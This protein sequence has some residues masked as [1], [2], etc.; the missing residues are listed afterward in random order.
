MADFD[1]PHID[2]TP[3]VLTRP[4]QAS[5]QNIGGGAAPRVRAQ[6]GARLQAEM[7][8]AFLE[9]DAI[10]PQDDR[11]ERP[12]G[13]FLEV[14]LR[15]GTNP[16]D[17]LE[18]KR[19]K[20]RPGAVSTTEDNEVRVALFVPDDARP[21]VERI[22]AEYLNGDVNARGE[23]P[24]KNKVEPIEAIRRARLETFWTDDP[25]TL[26]LEPQD[27]IWWEV[28]CYAELANK[29]RDA[30]QNINC[31][32]AEE[33]YWLRFPESIVIPIH[34]TRVTIELLLFASAGISELRRASASP[35]FFIE[36][37]HEEQSQ[38]T[39]NLAERV[40]WPAGD[41]PAVCLLDTG[42]NR[43]HILLEPA[44]SADDLLTVKAD[45]GTA[46]DAGHGTGMAGLALLG[47]LAPRLED[48]SEI[49][50]RHRVESVKILP[51]NGF[52]PN[53]PKSFGSITQSAASLAEINKPARKRVFCLAVTNDN[54][55]GARATTWSSAIDQ[56]AVGKMA[57][58][59]EDAPSRLLVVS[60]GNAPSEI[61]VNNILPADQLPIEDPSQAW[62]ALS[63]GGY[64]NKTDISDEGYDGW[65]AMATAGDLSPFT[66]TSVTWP[67][68]RTAFKPDVVMEAGNRAISPAGAEAL[69]LDSLALLTTGENVDTQPLI[70][71][72]AT[73]AAAAQCARL[74]TQL[75]AA[76]PEMW[77]ETIRAL[78]V[79]S[80][81]WTPKML[82]ELE[83]AG[84]MTARH[85]LL[86]RFGH[87]VPDLSRA[88]ASA[89]NHLALIAQNEIT[90]FKV[91]NGQKKFSDCHF[92][93]L[94]WPKD[95][96]EDLGEQDVRLKLTLS[97]FVEPNPGRFASIDA[98]RY[99]SFGLRF[100]L[101]RRSES[102]D[103]FLK[104]TNPMERDDP[105]GP[106]P[107]GGDNSGWK[108]GPNS[109]SA[110]S[111]HSD[112][113]V[114]PAVTLAARDIVCVKPVIGWWRQSARNC[115]RSGRYALVVTL[116]APNIEVDLHTP[117]QLAVENQV[118]IEIPF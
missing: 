15:R 118:D 102:E 60:A 48:L 69:N 63:V 66:R 81:E 3:R 86:R 40:I 30:A 71:F 115:R 34:A 80:A 10:R 26:P 93:K 47:D 74:A 94:P 107:P 54:V 56:V 67:Q 97:Y 104:R 6:H 31:I 5:R 64:T 38:W 84:R 77:P 96:L 2:I 17:T 23:P 52:P 11:L 101:K 72:T 9:A 44:V 7:Q 21:V 8:A 39:E 14:D 58:D 51:P 88:M 109:I 112:E 50:L 4:Y 55:S 98:Q 18:R 95:V 100:D 46:D 117:I 116:S 59:E 45:W 19:D 75:S 36:A 20:V 41:A 28:W 82:Q 73:S 99:Q 76:Y 35:T 108:F 62:N 70:P 22:V 105:L 83:D 111:L 61:D 91:E 33:H 57:G 68:S 27:E 89:N 65:T 29:V 78:I 32:V 106:G 43:A 24:R 16:V 113:W 103:D 90:P 13:V 79:H 53:N 42:V 1:K 25:E 12:E 49:N 87:G 85:P 37:D 92:Y 114:G 110:G